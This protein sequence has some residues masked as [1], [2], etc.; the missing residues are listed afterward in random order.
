[1]TFPSGEI[2]LHGFLYKP[3]GDGPFPAVLYNHGSER[4][5][6]AKPA[7]GNFFA[8][9]GYLL[10]MPHRRGHGLSPADRQVDA[11]YHQ[12]SKGIVA[13]H[14]IHIEDTAAAA[15]YL[16]GRSDVESDRVAVAGCSYGGI[17]TVLAAEKGIGLKTAIAFAPAA[18]S[19]AGSNSLQ[20]RLKR[21]VRQAVM[22]ILFLQAENDYNLAPTSV[23]AKE[24]EDS[25]KPHKRVI[26]PPYGKTRED[27]HGGFCVRGA[28]VWG[29]EALAF[30]NATLPR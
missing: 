19:W 22:P 6:G 5:P 2:K 13:L 12:G 10:F 9:K 15:R 28:R 4:E 8:D 1:M 20:A 29:D 25:G 26:F 30:L 24:M 27:G 16:R 21:A 3:A 17:Q 11:L 23:L 7:I 14:E 18:I